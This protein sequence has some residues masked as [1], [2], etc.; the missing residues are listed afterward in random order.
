MTDPR[1]PTESEISAYLGR[2]GYSGPV[3]ADF[4]TLAAL[5]RLHAEAMPYENFDVQLG[6]PVTRDPIAAFAKLVGRAR[7]GWCYEYNG[8]FAWMLAGIGFTV[9]HLAGAVMREAAGDM[10]IGNHLVPVVELDQPY[11]A[12]PSMG[13]M[14]PVPVVESPIEHGWRRFAFERLDGGWWRFRN[15]PDAPPPSMD[16]NLDVTDPE[17]LEDRCGF[18][19]TDGNSPFVRHAILQRHFAEAT[20][21]VVGRVHTII[22]ANG[23]REREIADPAAYAR[24]A[25]ERFGV[26]APDMAALWARITAA[27]KGGFLGGMDQAA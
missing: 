17:L 27:P 20:E 22:D 13:L 24:V 8:L 4:V 10:T 18:L 2:I 11:V 26:E 16:F 14:S 12:D 23:K 1:L 19:Q 5:N 25:R 9:R 15:H 7:G 21:V 6:V 3:R